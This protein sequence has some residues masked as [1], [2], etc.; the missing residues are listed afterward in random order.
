M[1]PCRFPFTT[2]LLR[3]AIICF[4][5]LALCAA[6]EVPRQTITDSWAEGKPKVVREVI[7]DGRGGWINDGDYKSYFENGQ[8]EANGRYRG[9]AK[10]GLWESFHPT[11]QRASKGVCAKGR[12][13]GKWTFWREDG[14]EN[15]SDSGEYSTLSVN[16]PGGVLSYEGYLRDKVRHGEWRYYW[17]DGQLQVEGSFRNGLRDGEW[18]FYGIDGWPTRL[19][20]SGVYDGDKRVAVIDLE[21]WKAI[22]ERARAR[23]MPVK[24]D[25][26]SIPAWFLGAK[27]VDDAVAARDA[28]RTADAPIDPIVAKGL[29]TLRVDQPRDRSVASAWCMALMGSFLG[30]TLGWPELSQGVNCNLTPQE[31]S[32]V[33]RAWSGLISLVGNDWMFWSFDCH[34]ATIHRGDPTQKM[35]CSLLT[36][37]LLRRDDLHSPRASNRSFQ[38]YALRFADR[39]TLSRLRGGGEAD[40]SLRLALGWLA[41]HQSPDGSWDGDGFMSNCG[42]L[43]TGTCD[44]PGAAP[45]DI[46]LTGLA[47][48]AFLGDGNTLSK[49]EHR[50]VVR[51]GVR[52]LLDRQQFFDT[53]QV[54][55]STERLLYRHSIATLA[56]SETLLF[57]ENPSL[58]AHVERAVE[59]LLRAQN[60]RSG[61]GY[62]SERRTHFLGHWLGVA[63]AMRCA[64]CWDST[65]W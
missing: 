54:G 62:A 31:P 27:S 55:E 33:V 56:L 48:L 3:L 60:P 20:I 4:F 43:G 6:Q 10:V 2:M 58:R 47:L 29:L 15:T 34:Q 46:G 7:A 30:H 25:R 37:P 38:P 44:G 17:P 36:L 26:A 24:F 42:K 50:D 53:G 45:H 18:L 61:W 59:F 41:A 9:G 14:A 11:G 49:G 23:E 40:E 35:E 51:R 8:L 22:E 28:H 1:S 39:K 13:S 5:A 32:E 16:Y 65:W 52:W 12:R 63:R 21:R 19:L 57:D 64:R